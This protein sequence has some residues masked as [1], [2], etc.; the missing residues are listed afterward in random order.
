MVKDTK[1]FPIRWCAPEVL[2]SGTYTT[3]SD[4]WAF[5]VVLFEIFS[6]GN[7]PYPDLSNEVNDPIW[8]YFT[9]LLA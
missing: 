6:R 5:A 8:S 2:N 9:W 3:K 4:V 7:L 1:L